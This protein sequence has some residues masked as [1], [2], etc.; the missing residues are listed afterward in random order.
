LVGAILLQGFLFVG[1][2]LLAAWS[3]VR[4]R[5]TP[6]SLKRVRVRR[7]ARELFLAKNLSGTRARTGVLIYVALSEHMAVRVADEGVSR[8]VDP[9]AWEAPMAALVAGLK[10]G[11]RAGGFTQAVALCADILALHA[12]VEMADTPHELPDAVV[13]LPRF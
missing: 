4:R 9:A 10:R 2:A 5:L 7:R 8:R 11:D 6:R 12:P 1:V 3:P 13:E